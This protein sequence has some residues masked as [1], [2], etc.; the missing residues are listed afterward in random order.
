[1]SAVCL[2]KAANTGISQDEAY[3]SSIAFVI[4]LYSLKSSFSFW[5][6]VMESYSLLPADSYIVYNKTILNDF[7][8]K[9]LILEEVLHYAYAHL[10]VR[11]ILHAFHLICA[12]VNE[13]IKCLKPL[14]LILLLSY[15]N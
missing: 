12:Q 2:S 10:K 3:T 14:D 15:L 1:M 5:V 4:S 7:D 11:Y 8:K 9:I 6:I 13:I